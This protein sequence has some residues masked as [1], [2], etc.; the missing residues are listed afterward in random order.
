MEQTKNLFD[1]LVVSRIDHST[2]DPNV[3]FVETFYQTS[4]RALT[5]L[6]KTRFRLQVRGKYRN[7]LKTDIAHIKLWQQYFPQG[8]LDIIIERSS[9]LKRNVVEILR[10]IGKVLLPYL[11]SSFDGTFDKSNSE[12]EFYRNL[13]QDLKTQ[14]EQSAIMLVANNSEDDSSG[15]EASESSDSSD[16]S[17][18]PTERDFSWLDRLHG[19]INCLMD[20]SSVIERAHYCLQQEQ[21]A[22]TISLK[23]SFNLS[24]SVRPFAMLIQDRF[25]KASISL[26]E[27]LAEANLERSLRIREL[28]SQEN[29]HDGDHQVQ[30]DA[31]TLFK[32]FSIFH[33]SGI[34][35]SVPANS[36]G[37]PT[38]A[39]HTSFLSVA[40]EVAFGRPRVPPLP[41]LPGKR[42]QC[43]YCRKFI[44]MQNRI[45]WKYVPG[46]ERSWRD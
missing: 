11:L 35:S 30:D 38:V 40:T 6:W 10:G 29:Q 16:S 15:M 31:G 34:G 27:R 18:S 25:P 4:A 3:G 2:Q 41:Q 43:D 44:S 45:E 46:E 24:E 28:M 7:K 19:Y 20:L 22:P 37:A 23:S 17:S 36:Y 32:P 14:L 21:D 5:H 26:V 13:V 39:S 33:D 1:D 42:F 12:T 9:S 8:R